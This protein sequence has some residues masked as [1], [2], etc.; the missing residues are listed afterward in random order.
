MNK[1]K[2]EVKLVLGGTEYLLKFN[3]NTYRIMGVNANLEFSEIADFFT[4]DPIN[5]LVHILYAGIENH[6]DYLGIDTEVT[7]KQVAAWS[8]DLDPNGKEMV[9]IVEA[10]TNSMQLGKQKAVV[11]P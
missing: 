2:G 6:N 11:K 4:N 10:F 8:G 3:M 1:L 5:G 9:N 7:F